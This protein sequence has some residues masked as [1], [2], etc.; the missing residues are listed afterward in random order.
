VNRDQGNSCRGG[1][2]GQS[3]D[4][5]GRATR[6]CRYGREQRKASQHRAQHLALCGKSV[7][8]DHEVLQ[9]VKEEKTHQLPKSQF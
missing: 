3:Q 8:V 2:T 7:N 1:R 6:I 9:K 5:A 4:N